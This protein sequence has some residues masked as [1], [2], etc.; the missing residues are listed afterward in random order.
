MYGDEYGDYGSFDGMDFYGD[1]DDQN[2]NF[3]KSSGMFE[4]NLFSEIKIEEL[5]KSIEISLKKV[6]GNTIKMIIQ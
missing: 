2:L 6:G 3:E 1:E 4:D 5:K